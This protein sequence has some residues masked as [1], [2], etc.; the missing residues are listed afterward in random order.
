MPNLKN[1]NRGIGHA[2][3]RMCAG[4]QRKADY[5]QKKAWIINEKLRKWKVKSHFG[6]FD[7]LGRRTPGARSHDLAQKP[8]HQSIDA[9]RQPWVI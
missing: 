1:P 3:R 6:L 2:N 4:Y 5:R 8:S 9:A 7:D